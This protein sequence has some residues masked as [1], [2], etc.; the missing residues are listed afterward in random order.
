MH[1]FGVCFIFDSRPDFE[2]NS[3]AGK[4]GIFAAPTVA[5]LLVL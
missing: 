1:L 2:H 4:S 3:M 5:V